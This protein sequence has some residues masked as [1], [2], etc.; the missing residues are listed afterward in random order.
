LKLGQ[1]AEYLDEIHA[2]EAIRK[3]WTAAPEPKRWREI[4][5]KHSK[6]YVRVGEPTSDLSWAEPA[7]MPLELVP[8]TDPTV[9]RVG[10]EVSALVLRH[11]APVPGFPVGIVHAGDRSATVRI[12]DARGQVS[13]PL[14]H[15]GRWL[16]RGT[17]LR[18]S[19]GGEAEWESDFATLTIEV[20][21]R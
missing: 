10:D 6:S 11:G 9:L 20:R 18:I 17:D 21:P 7:G 16:L 13:F 14:D 8:G 12:T 19:S 2:A 15:A 1:V 5:T 3:A 4:Y